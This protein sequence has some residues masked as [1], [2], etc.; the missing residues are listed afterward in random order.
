V[1]LLITVAM[2]TPADMVQMS[3]TAQV[4]LPLHP[5]AAMGAWKHKLISRVGHPRTSSEDCRRITTALSPH[6]QSLTE[7]TRLLTRLAERGG[8]WRIAIDLWNEL[9]RAGP[10]PDMF[11]YNTVFKAHGNGACWEAAL[12]L[13]QEVRESRIQPDGILG[14]SLIDACGKGRQWE[15]S[16]HLLRSMGGDFALHLEVPMY[17]CTSRACGGASQWQLG[18]SLFEE[19]QLLGFAADNDAFGA[20]MVSYMESGQW[21]QVLNTLDSLMQR[22]LAPDGEQSSLAIEALLQKGEPA[23]ACSL[24]TEMQLMELLPDGQV[25]SAVINACASGGLGWH[26]A[27]Q[28]L[29]Q[30]HETRVRPKGNFFAMARSTCENVEALADSKQWYEAVTLLE[31]AQHLWLFCLKG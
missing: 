21:Q 6:L 5:A 3:A 24:L 8:C 29:G 25:Y 11:A 27:R 4:A 19:L 14:T 28:V 30:L 26:D 20:A 31:E 1:L 18:I 13:M 17:A 7:Y 10:R 15:W 22:G 16:L 23:K 9:K 12:A 2:V